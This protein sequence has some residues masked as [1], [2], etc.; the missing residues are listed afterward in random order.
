[1]TDL[2]EG[3]P[4]KVLDECCS[5]TGIRYKIKKKRDQIDVKKI[6]LI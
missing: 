5:G 3:T 1:M 2:F 6:I 4:V